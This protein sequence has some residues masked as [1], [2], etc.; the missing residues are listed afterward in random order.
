MT[1]SVPNQPSSALSINTQA[2]SQV[3]VLPVLPKYDLLRMHA[4]RWDSTTVCPPQW[5]LSPV[6]YQ[7]TVGRC[8]PGFSAV[9]I[10]AAVGLF[11]TATL[12]VGVGINLAQG[13]GYFGPGP[14]AG[15]FIVLAALFFL[16]FG[17][18]NARGR[19]KA[20]QRVQELDPRDAVVLN[21]AEA[22]RAVLAMAA[23]LTVPTETPEG[24]S[25][26]PLSAEDRSRLLGDL[27]AEASRLSVI[28]K[29]AT[30]TQ[31]AQAVVSTAAA[32]AQVED[33]HADR[34]RRW[35]QTWGR[36]EAI[37][38][39]WA[40]LL[41]D[42]LA[43]LDHALLLDVSNVATARFIEAHGHARDLIGTRTVTDLPPASTLTEI[44]IAVR[45]LDTAWTD[46]KTRAER[47][48]YGWLPKADRKR[49][50]QAAALLATAADESLT[51]AA[52][53]NAGAKAVE[54]LNAIEAVPMPRVTMLALSERT[55]L[56]LAAVSTAVL[57]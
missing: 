50:R 37:D 46:A 5:D 54:L 1:D 39:A 7:R 9:S 52:R 6:E 57:A 45:A 31:A 30:F 34:K 35:A 16:I 53:A 2:D 36:F 26:P 40:D 29:T 44:Q 25:R 49:A 20:R 13:D 27:Y 33:E 19:A 47:A 56:P 17:V 14:V 55:R 12:G 21:S 51:V 10:L 23:P 11:P 42:P 28:E 15:T 18:S 43:V 8:G 48:G 22:R 24:T 32:A 4:R 3:S 41:T 38:L